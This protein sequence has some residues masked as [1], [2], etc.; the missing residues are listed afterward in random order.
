MEYELRNRFES[1]LRGGN[2]ALMIDHLSLFVLIENEQYVK[3][4][5]KKLLSKYYVNC[6]L[7]R[8]AIISSDFI[9]FPICCSASNKGRVI[10][11][12]NSGNLAAETT[13]I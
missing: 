10:N 7:N 5:I 3:Q 11:S 1:I 9:D 13:L 2:C 12:V 6:C 4:N 8:K